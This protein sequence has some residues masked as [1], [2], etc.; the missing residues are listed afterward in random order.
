LSWLRDV[1]F[2]G[3]VMYRRDYSE[4]DLLVQILTDRFGPKMFLVRGAKK[5][6]FKMTSA[7]LPFTEAEYIGRINSD[8]LSYLTTTKSTKMWRHISSDLVLQAYASYLLT[9]TAAAFPEG[10]PVG[11]AYDLIQTAL[12][13]MDD[14][15]DAQ[16]LTN[17]VEVK[18]LG[19]FGVAP[20]LQGCVIC[21]R[22]DLPLDYS[23]AL[24]GL[25]C[26]NHWDRDPYRLHARPKAVALLQRLAVWQPQQIG[27]VQLSDLTRRELQR[28]LD[29]IYTDQ[30]GLKLKSKVFLDELTSNSNRLK[31]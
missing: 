24:G 25:L 20:Y 28:I 5:R 23:E 1:E 13:R 30:V 29:H 17:L 14:Q 27:Q 6:G 9:L 2:R 31:K 19:E 16:L 12:E 26:Q 11:R 15:A 18:L 7:I 21:Q 3:M 10:N 8:G 22:N 4:R